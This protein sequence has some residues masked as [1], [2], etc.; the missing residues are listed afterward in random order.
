MELKRYVK[1]ENG[2]IYDNNKRKMI[3]AI[4]D[5]LNYFLW[6]DERSII[7]LAYNYATADDI[8]EL[9][10][11]KWFTLQN[12]YPLELSALFNTDDND[13]HICLSDLDVKNFH[14]YYSTLY[15]PITENEKVIRYELVWER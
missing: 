8:F 3:V 9:A 15:C 13:G 1:F 14:E 12:G 11:G 7:C 5:G 4:V 2:V 6:E 10:T